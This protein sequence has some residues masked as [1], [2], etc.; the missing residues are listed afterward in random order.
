MPEGGHGIEDVSDVAHAGSH[1]RLHF[2][3]GGV[4]MTGRHDDVRPL[5]PRHRIERARQLGSDGDERN[6][7]PS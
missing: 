4:G 6:P 1:T 3:G 2:P 5:Q 7:K